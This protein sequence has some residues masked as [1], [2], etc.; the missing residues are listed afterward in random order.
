MR[1]LLPACLMNDRL[2][3]PGLYIQTL[4]GNVLNSPYRRHPVWQSA[5]TVSVFKSARKGKARFKAG[6]YNTLGT[7]DSANDYGENASWQ[8]K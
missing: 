4:I 6:Q 7:L 2:I 3:Y 5:V 8:K 1:Q